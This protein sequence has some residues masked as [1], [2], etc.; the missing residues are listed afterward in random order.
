MFSSSAALAL[1]SNRETAQA[2]GQSQSVQ[3]QPDQ[4]LVLTV[5]VCCCSRMIVQVGNDGRCV[6]DRHWRRDKTADSDPPTHRQL[7]LVCPEAGHLANHCAPKVAWLRLLDQSNI[8]I[9]QEGQRLPAAMCQ[10]SLFASASL[11]VTWD[12][13]H[14]KTLNETLYGPSLHFAPCDNLGEGLVSHFN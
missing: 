11:W 9:N 3:Q 13:N 5:K 8:D 4:V 1:C 2:I 7:G 14:Q 6:A 10:S 12:P